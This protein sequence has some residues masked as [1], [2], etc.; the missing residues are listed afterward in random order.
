[1]VGLVLAITAT[2][3][4]FLLWKGK[5]A[6]TTALLALVVGASLSGGVIGRVLRQLVN[7]L[8][9]ATG[10]LTAELIGIAA[11]AVLG[12][13]AVLHFSHDMMPKHNASRATAVVAFALPLFGALI[14]GAFGAFVLSMSRVIETS[15]ADIVNA[16][17]GG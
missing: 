9:D 14:P 1:M 5:A 4:I 3:M 15:I 6:K 17:V 8:A 7:S 10:Q 11:P 12:V 13:W 16:F 2:I